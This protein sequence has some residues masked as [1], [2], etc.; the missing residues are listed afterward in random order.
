MVT[1]KFLSAP[2]S[3]LSG[4]VQVMSRLL[5]LKPLALA[6]SSSFWPLAAGTQTFSSTA[7]AVAPLPLVGRVGAG[8][9]AAGASAAG[10]GAGAGVGAAAAGA[11]GGGGAAGWAA[12]S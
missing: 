12:G 7:I 3:S 10:A 2:F 1:V 4:L 9:G 6:T 8:G 5:S 11:G